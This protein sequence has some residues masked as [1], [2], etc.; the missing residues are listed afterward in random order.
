MIGPVFAGIIGALVV[1]LF[2][3]RDERAR[4]RASRRTTIGPKPETGSRAI[5][6]GAPTIGPPSQ[7]SAAYVPHRLH[8]TSIDRINNNKQE[9]PT[10]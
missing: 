7:P 10:R 5:P 6:G 2:P 1:A 8:P 3:T 4:W 9:N